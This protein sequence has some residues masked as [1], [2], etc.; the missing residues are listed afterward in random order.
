ML[1]N[2]LGH[3]LLTS[4]TLISFCATS[5]RAASLEAFAGAISGASS[6]NTF[7]TA[8]PI[9]NFFG[10][11]QSFLVGTTGNGISDCGLQ[12]G[13][14]D[15]AAAAGPL[16]SPPESLSNVSV[17]GSGGGTFTGSANGTANYGS[18]GA[19]ANGQFTGFTGPSIFHVA[20]G[21]G[22]FDDMLTISSPNHTTGT[23]GTAQ[24]AFTISG[25]MSTSG[26]NATYDTNVDALL[27][28]VIAGTPENIF[29]AN[30]YPTSATLFACSGNTAGLTVVAGSVSGSATCS[31]A[32]TVTFK[33]GVPFEIQAGLLVQAA[34]S[35]LG[36]ATGSMTGALT[37]ISVSGES[38]FSVTGASGTPYPVPEPSTALL[39]AAGITGLVFRYRRT[40][41][42]LGG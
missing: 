35:S 28:A 4:A 25:S 26:S 2:R 23:L 20:A 16:T 3:L 8:T 10:P 14:Q 31:N 12:G 42:A 41:G 38:N 19:S 29:H 39:L 18:I 32:G 11:G 22:L 33:Y 17:P 21:F 15:V 36:D 27:R 13:Y 5:A 6:C 24:F 37:G 1:L 34:P 40:R 7:M 9:A 30:I